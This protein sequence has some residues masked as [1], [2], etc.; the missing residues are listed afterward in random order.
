METGK[1]PLRQGDEFI[2]EALRDIYCSPFLTC[3]E[4][5]SIAFVNGPKLRK[6]LVATELD[7]KAEAIPRCPSCG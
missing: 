6:A 3:S 2:S 1:E 5:N 4:C 7:P